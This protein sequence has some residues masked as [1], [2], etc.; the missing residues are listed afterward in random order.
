MNISDL[1]EQQKHGTD[2]FP[3]A[4]YDSYSSIPYQ[5]H[6][7]DEF[8]YMASG[9][10]EYNINGKRI[11]LKSGNCVFCSGRNLHS[12][13]AEKNQIIHFKALLCDRKYLF[14]I[15]DKCCTYL[16]K[17]IKRVYNSD[18]HEEKEIINLV[19]EIC[20]LM[21]KQHLGYELEVKSKLIKI[22]FLIIKYDLF[23]KQTEYSILSP[24]KN[25]LSA[26]EYIHTNYAEKLCVDK[27][28]QLTGYS[29]TYFERFFKEYIGMTPSQYIMMYRLNMSRNLLFETG[30][31]VTDIANSC[32]F[33]N[34]SYFIR[35]FKK[36]Y[37][38]TPNKYRRM[39]K[40]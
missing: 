40:Q 30:K 2:A 1:M 26:V 19:A 27:L 22:Y 20:D 7:E 3:V 18:V 31:S 38:L 17:E 23:E 4:F 5:W 39:S 6:N 32:G 9:E 12:M 34:V 10:A 25:L 14:G 13:I 35:E 29:T 8:I 21:E 37:F 36:H 24:Q 11:L 16:N 28:A 15:G 33:A